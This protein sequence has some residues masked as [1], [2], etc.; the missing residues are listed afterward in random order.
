M[1]ALKERI[2]TPFD[3]PISRPAKG[4]IIFMVRRRLVYTDTGLCSDSRARSASYAD[5]CHISSR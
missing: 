5:F 3:H 4:Y 1:C 2:F